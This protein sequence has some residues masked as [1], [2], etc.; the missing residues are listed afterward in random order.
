MRILFLALSLMFTSCNA[1][2]NSGPVNAKL[3]LRTHIVF[4]DSTLAA[5]II[6]TED[7][8]LK[9]VSAYDRSAI[10]QSATPVTQAAFIQHLKRNVLNWP[11]NEIKKFSAF[12][13]KIG[14][15][16][17]E[18]NINLP[19]KIIL[20]KTTG[21]DIGGADAPYTRQNAIMFSRPTVSKTPDSTMAK[22]LVHE[23]AHVYSRHNKDK[24]TELY[25]IFGFRPSD[26]IKLPKEWDDRRISNPDAPLLNTIMDVQKD[27]KSMT[28]TPLIYTRNPVYDPSKGGGVFQGFTFQLMQVEEKEGKWQAVFMDGNPVLLSP[29]PKTLPDF[30]Q[31]IGKN[32]N[33]IINPEEIMASNFQLLVNKKSGLPNPEILEKMEK[34]ISEK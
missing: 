28:V 17:D 27:G 4:A 14:P 33:Y 18:L 11:K 31:Q 1:Q 30:W 19:E 32:T 3:T 12:A 29:S 26:T 2:N 23:I 15:R 22:I 10:M 24:R 7:T 20:I 25:N 16:L 6:S 13:K 21:G 9:A 5:K 8:Y 34:I